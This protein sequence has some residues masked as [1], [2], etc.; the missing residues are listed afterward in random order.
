M[1]HDAM[2]GC[3]GTNIRQ[4]LS[5]SFIIS[6]REFSLATQETLVH[7]AS[8]LYIGLAPCTRLC[9][10]DLSKCLLQ[11]SFAYRSFFCTFVTRKRELLRF[12]QSVIMVVKSRSKNCYIF[13]TL[14]IDWIRQTSVIQRDKGRKYISLSLRNKGCKS[15]GYAIC[16]LFYTRKY[17]QPIRR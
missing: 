11:R 1:Q 4:G 6:A 5:R 8:P 7:G 2:S 16:P 13:A 10:R 3:N 12:Q 9:S 14:P 17:L 15:A